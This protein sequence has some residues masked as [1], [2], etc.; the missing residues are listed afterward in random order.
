MSVSP[1]SN[2]DIAEFP[3][4]RP[5]VYL[6]TSS[7]N[8]VADRPDR[9]QLMESVKRRT[10]AVFASVISAAEV[11]Q[12]RDPDRRRLLSE[13]L[14]ALHGDLVLLDHPLEMLSEAA[15]AHL[16]GEPDFLLRASPG[17]EYLK[18]CLHSSDEVDLDGIQAYAGRMDA[19]VQ[20]FIDE[21]RRDGVSEARAWPEV[22][23]SL[24]QEPRFT[25]IVARGA[26][27]ELTA[28]PADT[29]NGFAKAHDPLRALVAVTAQVAGLGFG[30]SIR[31]PSRR[32]LPNG[33]DFFQL[34]YL[35]YVDGFV[36]DDGAL[37]EAGRQI[38]PLLGYEREVFSTQSFIARLR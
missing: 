35:G 27:P 20:R 22:A 24:V 28:V 6:D 1:D 31:Q 17:S 19:R 34:I 21:L 13:T 29:I 10:S 15:R 23:A 38:I 9:P 12:T 16:R 7:W 30:R 8:R 32:R 14:L 3:S 5:R 26:I 36:T 18:A 11:L 33:R 4:G 2:E 37:A 25:E